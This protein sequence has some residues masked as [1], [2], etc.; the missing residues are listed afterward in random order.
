MKQK[1]ITWAVAIVICAIV[2]PFYWNFKNGPDN[3]VD[4]MLNGVA[5]TGEIGY[6]ADA[7]VKEKVQAGLGLVILQ[8]GMKKDV[9]H[10]VVKTEKKGDGTATVSVKLSSEGK[11]AM[12]DFALKKEDGFFGEWRITG[13]SKGK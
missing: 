7:T 6:C 13:I 8:S 9:E 3:T 5:L 4:N 1:I 2:F 11:S 10:D 12:V